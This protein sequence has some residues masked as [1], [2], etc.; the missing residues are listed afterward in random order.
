VLDDLVACC[1][2]RRVISARRGNVRPS[3]WRASPSE[4]PASRDA[5]TLRT[6]PALF[7]GAIGLFGFV[8]A[9]PVASTAAAVGVAHDA[10]SSL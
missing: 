3:L 6:R 7:N 1:R 10:D 4:G 9:T 5:P 8:D 2:C